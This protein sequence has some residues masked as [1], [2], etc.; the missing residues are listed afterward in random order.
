MAVLVRT[1]KHYEKLIHNLISDERE[2][3]EQ[4]NEEYKMIFI[5]TKFQCSKAEKLSR[6][7]FNH[8]ISVLDD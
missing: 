4:M 1:E 5:L 6:D 7:S 3:D 8:L 2:V